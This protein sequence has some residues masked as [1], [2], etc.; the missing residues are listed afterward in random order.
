MKAS[1]CVP[2][3]ALGTPQ[4]LATEFS[5]I[6]A[7]SD[8]TLIAPASVSRF[9]LFAGKTSSGTGWRGGHVGEPERSW[10]HW[11]FYISVPLFSD[12]SS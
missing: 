3:P 2:L 7:T 8:H 10:G 4:H 9:L 11:S 6:T 5:S 1:N 12:A